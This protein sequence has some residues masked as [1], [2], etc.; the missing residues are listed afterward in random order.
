MFIPGNSIFFTRRKRNFVAG[1]VTGNAY[2]QMYHPREETGKIVI[3][4]AVEST[5]AIP[6]PGMLLGDFVA[7]YIFH[8]ISNYL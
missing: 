8:V 6:A 5:T 4:G 2:V 7:W 3:P 1:F